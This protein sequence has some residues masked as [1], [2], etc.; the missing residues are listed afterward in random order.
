M[1]MLHLLLPAFH[2]FQTLL[3]LLLP[4]FHLFQTL[5]LLLL[6]TSPLFQLTL[7]QDKTTPLLLQ[8]TSYPLLSAMHLLQSTLPQYLPLLPVTG[9]VVN[10]ASLL[11]WRGRISC[12]QLNPRRS[13]LG[14]G[15]G[16]T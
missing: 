2:L 3:C 9:E 12:Y 11:H 14:E 15:Q 16:T 6:T 5:L 10:L 7:C 4:V 13:T 1:T 8:S